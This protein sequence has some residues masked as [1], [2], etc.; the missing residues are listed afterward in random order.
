VA[1]HDKDERIHKGDVDKATD[2]LL[3]SLSDPVQELL[4]EFI[5]SKDLS[6]VWQKLHEFCG[7]RSGEEGLAALDLYWAGIKMGVTELM[8][9]FLLRVDRTDKSLEAYGPT[10]KKTEQHKHVL[11]RNAQVGHR[12]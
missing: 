4:Q 12:L 10:W 7:P 11:V 3:A 5:A 6:M 8:T 9:E 2:L 1:K